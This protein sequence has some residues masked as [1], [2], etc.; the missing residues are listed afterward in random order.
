MNPNLER[1][2]I[3]LSSRPRIPVVISSVERK[4]QI[5]DGS[6]G[7]QIGEGFGRDICSD[8]SNVSRRLPG[9][10]LAAFNELNV[11]ETTSALYEAIN[12]RT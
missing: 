2:V 6:L 8:Q 11:A 1:L 9:G 3:V 4:A 7:E 10:S 5:H 12:K